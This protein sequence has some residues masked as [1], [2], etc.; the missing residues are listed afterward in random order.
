MGRR[1]ILRFA[2][3]AL[4]LFA[5]AFISSHLL[6]QSA[7]ANIRGILKL[8]SFGKPILAAKPADILITGDDPTLAVFQDKRVHGLEFEL[9]GAFQPNGVFSTGPIH[10]KAMYVLRGGQRLFVT[11][12]CD[13][14]SIRTY[15]P[16]VCWCCQE[17]T[18]LDIRERYDN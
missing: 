2:A 18:E 8:N 11:Y 6:A 10:T 13:V 4:P 1:D 17:E 9:V 5:N 16:G 15:S 12:W 7:A 14:C 3:S